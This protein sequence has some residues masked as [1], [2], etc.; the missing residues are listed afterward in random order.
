MAEWR[1]VAGP[2]EVLYPSG[3]KDAVIWT[4][5]I[6]RDG[7]QRKIQIVLSR[8]LF[9]ATGHPSDDAAKA[10]ETKGRNYVE[11]VLDRDDPPRSREANTAQSL[12]DTLLDSGEY[13]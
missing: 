5:E 7:D 9:A 4:W 8:T 3:G 1:I 11:A 10:R 12:V 13:V 6:E 2:E